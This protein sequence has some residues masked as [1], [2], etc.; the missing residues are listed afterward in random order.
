MYLKDMRKQEAPPSSSKE[1]DAE[2]Y[3]Q[4]A[5]LGKNRKGAKRAI[6]GKR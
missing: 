4:I 5:H 1:R 3:D 6:E 2:F